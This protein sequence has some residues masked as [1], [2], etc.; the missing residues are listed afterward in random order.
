MQKR[1][2]RIIF[3]A[4]RTTRTLT[5]FNELNWI[6]F[7]IESYIN[8]CSTAFK[9]LGG[10]TPYYIDSMLK[11]NSEIHNRS[12]RFANLSFHCPVLKK[13]RRRPDF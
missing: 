7:F 13:N 11:T 10:T 9:R 6:P 5:M 2:A 4:E 3:E 12:T 8:R 1:A